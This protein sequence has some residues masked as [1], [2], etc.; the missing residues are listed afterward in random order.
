[1]QIRKKNERVG[2]S[3]SRKEGRSSQIDALQTR[4]PSEEKGVER[5]NVE[6]GAKGELSEKELANSRSPRGGTGESKSTAAAFR[7]GNRRYLSVRRS[8]E[9]DVVLKSSWRKG[10]RS[11]KSGRRPA[12]F[13]KKKAS[14]RLSKN[15]FREE[16]PRDSPV[17]EKTMNPGNRPQPRGHDRYR[18]KRGKEGGRGRTMP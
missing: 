2:P 11:K 18:T 6:S 10:C 8:D 12:D 1:M 3:I 14:S 7:V 17:G 5:V 13:A 15:H 9:A 16:A 4:R